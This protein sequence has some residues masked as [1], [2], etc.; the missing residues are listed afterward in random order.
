MTAGLPA[1]LRAAI[2]AHWQPRADLAR[3]R[4]DLERRGKGLDELT[5]ADL[6]PY[7]QLHAGGLAASR[8]L[9]TWV[10]VPPGAR[11]LD[12]GAGLG[13]TARL[14]AEEHAARI[15]AVDLSDPITDVGRALTAWLG[16][17]DRVEHRTAEIGDLAPD[18][19]F[20]LV[21]LQHVDMHVPHKEALYRACRGHL[22]PE[23]RIIWHDWLAGPGGTPRWPVPWSA[24]GALSFLIAEAAF[25]DA[26]EATGLR[27]R[28]FEDL[29]A[30]TD[31]WYADLERGLT[32]ALSRMA[33][34]DRSPPPHLPRLLQE[35][36][37]LRQN[38]AER[39]IGAFFAE[40][41]PY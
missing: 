16:L 20:D 6:A 41:T 32:R 33:A 40:A 17:Q 5:L 29:T 1:P 9:A 39:R 14:L 31:G 38:L 3:I 26:L 30:D 19:P 24:D 28:R 11:I 21:W 15:L 34:A 7:D 37:T 36:R 12:V 27:L 22:H 4:A 25:R 35:T 13:G 10:D 18:A 23:G 8:R 2:A